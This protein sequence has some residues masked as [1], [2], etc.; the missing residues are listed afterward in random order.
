MIVYRC[1][2]KLQSCKIP[3][4]HDFIV[5][6]TFQ[7]SGV[8]FLADEDEDEDEDEEEEEKQQPALSV[9]SVVKVDKECWTHEPEFDKYVM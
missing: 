5:P 2:V 3:V 1:Q 9:P 4:A 6:L 8:K 7:P